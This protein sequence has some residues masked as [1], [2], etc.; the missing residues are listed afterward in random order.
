MHLSTVFIARRIQ[1]CLVFLWLTKY[2]TGWRGLVLDFSI[3]LLEMGREKKN[4]RG[5][6]R[7]KR[8]EEV[9][10]KDQTN[11]EPKK[12]DGIWFFLPFIVNFSPFINL[13]LGNGR[14]R[15]QPDTAV[16]KV[17]GLVIIL[18]FHSVILFIIFMLLPLFLFF[19]LP[20]FLFFIF[21][22]YFLF[23]YFLFLRSVTQISLWTLNLTKLWKRVKDYAWKALKVTNLLEHVNARNFT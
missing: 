8:G 11:Y 2:T 16:S 20:H 21:S 6:G 22:F 9:G 19:S 5:V 10:K 12:W 4:R 15:G 1:I 17:G 7:G 14:W 23:L 3:Y 13:I 18:L